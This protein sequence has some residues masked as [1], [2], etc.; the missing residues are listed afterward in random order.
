MKRFQKFYAG[1]TS[2]VR[3][4]SNFEFT[5]GFRNHPATLAN[6]FLKNSRKSK[7]KTSYNLNTL[8]PRSWL[9]VKCRFLYDHKKKLGLRERQVCVL[10][11][12]EEKLLPAFKIHRHSGKRYLWIPTISCYIKW[13]F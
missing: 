5:C 6:L 3:P 13:L 1:L 8:T 4:L 11:C 12:A 10:C 7:K 9:R 2:S